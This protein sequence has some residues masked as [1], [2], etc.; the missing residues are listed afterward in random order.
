MKNE[1]ETGRGNRAPRLRSERHMSGWFSWLE[2]N[3]TAIPW[4]AT[5]GVLLIGLFDYFAGY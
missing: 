3:R 4:I 2:R 1:R 5:S